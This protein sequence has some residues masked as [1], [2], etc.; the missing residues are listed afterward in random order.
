VARK[1]IFKAGYD[2]AYGA[3]SV[4]AP[5]QRLVQDP[6]AVKILDGSVAEG[7][8]V[9]VTAGR[10][11]WSLLRSGLRIVCLKRLVWCSSTKEEVMW[12]EVRPGICC[13][14]TFAIGEIF[15]KPEKGIRKT[16]A[17]DSAK[18]LQ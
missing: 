7:D 11:G 1:A 3:A 12:C 10:T 17:Q 5:I 8:H 15:L 6:L 4:E 2:R 9:V 16:I 18:C 13:G 14:R